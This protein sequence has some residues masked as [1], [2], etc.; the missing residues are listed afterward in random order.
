MHDQSAAAVRLGG[1]MVPKGILAGE[2]SLIHDG[3]PPVTHQS[4]AMQLLPHHPMVNFQ[5][6]G[7]A[8]GQQVGPPPASQHAN[9][10][11]PH[12]HLHN[13]QYLQR[14][15]QSIEMQQHGMQ[16]K[17]QVQ[18]YNRS[19]GGSGGDLLGIVPTM[20]SITLNLL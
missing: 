4:S 11:I 1:S 7:N 9:F 10:V 6:P 5:G 18:P 8:P 19:R 3:F 2:R 13:Q 15:Q 14:D 12:N 20:P 17:P 16:Q